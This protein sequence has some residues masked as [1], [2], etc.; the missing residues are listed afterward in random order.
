MRRLISLRRRRREFIARWESN[1]KGF[2]PETL[3]CFIMGLMIIIFNVVTVAIFVS[4]SLAE[5]VQ[6]EEE[7]W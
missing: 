7:A 2:I 5:S 4:W 1:P 3:V 6:E